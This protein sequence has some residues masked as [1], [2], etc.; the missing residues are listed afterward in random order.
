M[1]NSRTWKDKTID[2]M[3]KIAANRYLR[4]IRDGMAVII[5]V[6][7]VGSFFTIV[8]QLPITAW[9]N[10][11]KPY[12]AGLAIP[13]NFSMGF[14]A[15][16]AAFAIAGRLAEDYH[17]DHISTGVVS[18]MVFLLLA[19]KPITTTPAAFKAL[20]LKAAATVVPLT[21]FGAA[22]LFT[23]MLAGILTAEVTRI[24]RDHHLVITL[25]DGVP[26]AVAA[27][28]SALIPAT[29]LIVGAWVIHV[30]LNFD[31]N[32]FLQWVFS[33]LAYFGRDNLLSVIVPILLTDIVWLFGIHGAALATPIFWPLWYPNLNDNL[34]AISKG[35][36]AATVPHFMTEQ[37]F[38]WF[39]YI[40]GAGATLSLCILLAF[41]SKSAYGKTIGRV[42]I[43]P[44]IFNINEPVIFGVPIVMNPYFA[45]P[46]VLAPL[47]MGIITWAATVLH[48][49]S[50]TVALV[51]WTLPGP[52]GALMTTAWDW[53]AAVLCIINIIVATFIYYPFFKIWDRNQLKAEQDAAKADAE[54]AAQAAVAK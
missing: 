49:V 23:A 12:A 38:Q 48:L 47:T 13:I 18:V 30:G 42:T 31:V 16:Y 45:I 9:T 33:P 52:I 43:I 20:G 46:F 7:I 27:S 10:F 4:A 17:F 15:I 5:P 29:F 8:T 21:H 1:D 25:P 22:G 35:A 36:T 19:V 39:V 26:P 51:P 40:G 11:I 37:F 14:M 34:A 32:A 44:G 54:K 24:C 50:R 53:R 6:T 28:F 41:F 3:S 2:V